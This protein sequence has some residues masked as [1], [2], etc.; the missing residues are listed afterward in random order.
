MGGMVTG[1]REPVNRIVVKI[2]II[3][4]LHGFNPQ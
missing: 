1:W 2:L 4:E 3:G